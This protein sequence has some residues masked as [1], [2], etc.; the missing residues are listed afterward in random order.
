MDGKWHFHCRSP[1]D[2]LFAAGYDFC[3]CAAIYAAPLV[4]VADRH[5]FHCNHLCFHANPSFE[6]NFVWFLPDNHAEPQ[7]CFTHLYFPV[8][9]CR[10]IVRRALCLK[11]ENFMKIA[12]FVFS[13]EQ[14]CFDTPFAAVTPAMHAALTRTAPTGSTLRFITALS[15]RLTCSFICVPVN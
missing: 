6:K 15:A 13:P 14:H 10:F 8:T 9:K 2:V 11:E 5:N 4:W 7:R 3:S 1:A 12:C